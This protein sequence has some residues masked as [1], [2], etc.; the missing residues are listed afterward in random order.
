[1]AGTE[2]RSQ[3]VFTPECNS[4]ANAIPDNSG[5]VSRCGFPGRWAPELSGIAFGGENEKL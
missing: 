2:L 1:M 3:L 4:R 5:G